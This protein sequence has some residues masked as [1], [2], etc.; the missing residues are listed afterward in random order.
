MQ[1]TMPLYEFEEMQAE[2]EKLKK[3]RLSNYVNYDLALDSNGKKPVSIIFDQE[4]AIKDIAAANPAIK[5][6]NVK[7]RDG[8]LL[9]PIKVNDGIRLDNGITIKDIKQGDNK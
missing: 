1:V 8:L 7:T 5:T 2:I 3:E 4:K 9:N 6:I